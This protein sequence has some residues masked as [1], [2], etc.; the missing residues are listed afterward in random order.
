MKKKMMDCVPLVDKYPSE[1][2]LLALDLL[3]YLSKTRWSRIFIPSLVRFIIVNH[4]KLVV[5][6]MKLSLYN[7]VASKGILHD[8]WMLTEIWL[9]MYWYIFDK[10]WY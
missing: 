1:T 5:N 10:Y 6:I 7:I 9:S 4:F 8:A 2:N 3:L